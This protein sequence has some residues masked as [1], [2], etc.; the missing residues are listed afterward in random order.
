MIGSASRGYGSN[1]RQ[2]PRALVSKLFR[3]DVQKL[4]DELQKPGGDPEA[5]AT[6]T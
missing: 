5:T 3:M 1:E 4:A 6:T 2:S